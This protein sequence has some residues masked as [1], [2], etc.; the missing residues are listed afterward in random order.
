MAPHL[1]LIRF[2]VR[3]ERAESLGDFSPPMSRYA[4]NHKNVRIEVLQNKTAEGPQCVLI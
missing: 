2:V 4:W 3:Y 1:E